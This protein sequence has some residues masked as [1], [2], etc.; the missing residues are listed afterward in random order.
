MDSVNRF[1]LIAAGLIIT[2]GLV[3][4]A[5]RMADI[6][7]E[8]A[9]YVMEEFRMFGKDIKEEELLQYDGMV[10]SGSDV[11]NFIMRNLPKGSV[12][13]DSAVMVTVIC[14]SEKITY[15]TYEEA[16]NIKNFS[17]ENYINP[18]YLFQG[19]V[20]RNENGVISEVLFERR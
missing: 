16:K 5:F 6:G 17:H 11:V 13:R 3:F 1:F 2:A 9:E 15:G 4:L 20:I 7:T 18:T 8:T 12:Y 14:G 19:T 10:V